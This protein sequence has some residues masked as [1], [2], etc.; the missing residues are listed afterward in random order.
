MIC[1]TYLTT[2]ATLED[3]SGYPIEFAAS[4]VAAVSI[5]TR[6]Q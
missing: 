3:E 6:S 1:R 5:I 2:F 4:T